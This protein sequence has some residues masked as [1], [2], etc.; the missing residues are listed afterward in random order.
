[1]APNQR[2][3]FSQTP[4]PKTETSKSSSAGQTPGPSA[5]TPPGFT[6]LRVVIIATLSVGV[7]MVIG[8]ITEWWTGTLNPDDVRSFIPKALF[9]IV[10]SGTVW[11]A[12]RRS[13][14]QGTDGV[15]TF[16]IYIAAAL[17]IVV[18]GTVT[19]FGIKQHRRHLVQIAC[20]EHNAAFKRQ[21][22]SIKQ[23]AHG[24]LKIG[25]TGSDVSRFFVEHRMSPLLLPE[26]ER[27]GILYSSKCPPP[28]CGEEALIEVRVKVSPAGTVTDEP[29]VDFGYSD[30]P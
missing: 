11:R 19:W 22:E 2:S 13:S 4:E 5:P 3:I 10:L 18:I 9:G 21:L 14:Q 25:A 26:S 30:C 27:G 24:Q 29:T 17:V 6:F 8:F 12:M 7:L 20:K 28:Y 15:K 23:D 16:G 1:M